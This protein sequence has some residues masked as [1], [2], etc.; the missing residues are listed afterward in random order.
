M[1]KEF[2]SERVEK[3]FSGSLEAV[4]GP[5]CQ[6]C[7]WFMSEFSQHGLCGPILEDSSVVRVSKGESPYKNPHV[8]VSFARFSENTGENSLCAEI[9]RPQ[10]RTI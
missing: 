9:Q 3:V 1:R 6:I 4:T 2:V 8:F 10:L 7:E 5:S